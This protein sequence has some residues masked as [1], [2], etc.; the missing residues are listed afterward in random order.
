MSLA[1]PWLQNAESTVP[2]G[3]ITVPGTG[4]RLY[5]TGRVCVGLLAQQQRPRDPGVHA[6]LLQRLLTTPEPRREW[7]E[8]PRTFYLKPPLWQR[9]ARIWR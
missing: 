2:P 5:W 8:T 7:H 9:I 1:L 3:P 4:R 6:E